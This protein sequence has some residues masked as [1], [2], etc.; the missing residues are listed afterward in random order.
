MQNA[1]DMCVV[2][3]L[4]YVFHLVKMSL[5]NAVMCIFS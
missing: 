5:G 1:I 3:C 2:A 4:Y